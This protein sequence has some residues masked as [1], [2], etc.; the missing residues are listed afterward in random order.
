MAGKRVRTSRSPTFNYPAIPI[1]F[2]WPISIF[3]LYL[4]TKNIVPSPRPLAFASF[5]C[6]PHVEIFSNASTGRS[7][8]SKPRPGGVHAHVAA[9]E[10]DLLK[11][12][13]YCEAGG[14]L[15]KRDSYRATPLLLAAEK[16]REASRMN[17]QL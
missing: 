15:E 11:L 7:S 1:Q 9:Y 2:L 3:D 4:A 14:D 17:L 13:R 16:V 6:V 12:R 10:G 5:L 8:R